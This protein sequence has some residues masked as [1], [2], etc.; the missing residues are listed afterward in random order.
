M[1]RVSRA[2]CALLAVLLLLCLTFPYWAFVVLDGSKVP[3]RGEP[4]EPDHIMVVEADDLLQT[5]GKG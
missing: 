2:G 5:R 1:K 4:N 3:M